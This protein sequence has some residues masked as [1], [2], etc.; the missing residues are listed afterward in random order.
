M[1]IRQGNKTSVIKG[2]LH[3]KHTGDIVGSTSLQTIQ[4]QERFGK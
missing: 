2:I 4:I 1:G 3:V